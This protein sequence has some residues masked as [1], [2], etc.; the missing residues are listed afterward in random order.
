VTWWE[1]I[2]VILGSDLVT[3]IIVSVVTM[4]IVGKRGTRA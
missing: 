2:A 1:V 4:A 3:G